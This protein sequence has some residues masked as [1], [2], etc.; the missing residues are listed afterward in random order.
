MAASYSSDT[1]PVHRRAEQLITYMFPPALPYH[2]KRLLSIQ[3]AY[4]KTMET[5]DIWQ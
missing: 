3:Y 1:F 2:K 4:A 5:I